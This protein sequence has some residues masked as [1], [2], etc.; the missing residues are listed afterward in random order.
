M[1]RFYDVGLNGALVPMNKRAARVTAEGARGAARHSA[2][3]MPQRDRSRSK[4]HVTNV[5]RQQREA[6]RGLEALFA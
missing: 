3:L 6:K 1:K 5:R 4:D 2:D